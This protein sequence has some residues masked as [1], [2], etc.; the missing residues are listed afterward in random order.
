MATNKISIKK[1]NPFDRLGTI[2]NNALD[3]FIKNLPAD[4]KLDDILRLSGTSV[5]NDMK[6]KDD[7]NDEDL[8]KLQNISGCAF[9]TMFLPDNSNPDFI[10]INIDAIAKTGKFNDLQKEFITN[11]LNPSTD[12]SLTEYRCIVVSVESNIL[13]STLSCEEQ[14]PLLAATAVGKASVPYWQKQT[15]NPRS[16]WNPYVGS[17]ATQKKWWK[18]LLADL[19]GA[20]GG[21]AGGLIGAVGG[22][23]AASISYGLQ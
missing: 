1:F 17:G 6:G 12:L 7:Y 10:P 14:F 4:F 16:P 5:L 2:H 3:Y 8:L 22:A 13:N 9:N 23:A 15:S 18:Y 19:G 20:A 21:A 11:L